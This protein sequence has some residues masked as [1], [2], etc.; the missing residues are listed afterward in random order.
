MIQA[1]ETGPCKSR[2]FGIQL[3]HGTSN[4]ADM[5]KL[6]TV[7]DGVTNKVAPSNSATSLVC[8]ENEAY[9]RGHLNSI[10]G[11]NLP[12]VLTTSGLDESPIYLIGR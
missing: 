1:K 12:A 5:V 4:K 9:G 7:G 2:P 8:F 3:L 6:D 10:H 11:L